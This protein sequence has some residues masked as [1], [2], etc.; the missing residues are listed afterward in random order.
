MPLAAALI[1]TD[2][3]T[4]QPIETALVDQ[5][6]GKRSGGPAPTQDEPLEGYELVADEQLVAL[7][8]NILLFRKIEAKR[9]DYAKTLRPCV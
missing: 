9:F 8:V 7:P 2:V 4:G 6:M 5:V 1:G 3:G